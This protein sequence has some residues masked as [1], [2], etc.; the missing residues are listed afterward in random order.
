MEYNKTLIGEIVRKKRIEKK[1]DAKKLAHECKLTYEEYLKVE[2]DHLDLPPPKRKL[3][4]KCLSI[5]PTVWRVSIKRGI[6]GKKES[7][8]KEVP[9]MP[10]DDE[11]TQK[12]NQRHEG[13]YYL[14]FLLYLYANGKNPTDIAML[15][16]KDE[17]EIRD[18]IA[19]VK[20]KTQFKDQVVKIRE[21]HNELVELSVL[22]MALGFHREVTEV[23]SRGEEVTYKRYFPPS[24]NA[25]KYWLNNRKS[26]HWREN[27]EIT[28][29][30]E[31][32]KLTYNQLADKAKEL[33]IQV[34][35][36]ENRTRAIETDYKVTDKNKENKE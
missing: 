17:K 9:F 2:N 15:L 5:D 14:P 13:P 8:V 7:V 20:Q 12:Y 16:N 27:K 21:Y 19:G 25:A 28:L 31:L 6:L 3:L 23:N 29:R 26:T 30:S 1:K 18:L 10:L 36:D 4:M 34:E 32:S 11:I 33:G 35:G 24:I 22:D